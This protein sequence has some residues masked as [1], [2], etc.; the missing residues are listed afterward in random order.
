MSHVQV[1]AEDPNDAAFATPDSPYAELVWLPVLGPS[2]FLLWRHLARRLLHAPSG[3]TVDMLELSAGLGLGIGDGSQ[4]A[5]A[6]TVRRVQRFGAIRFAPPNSLH[7][8][9]ALP[10]VPRHQL[11]RLHPVVLCHHERL[12]KARRNDATSPA[13]TERSRSGRHPLPC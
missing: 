3:F 5:M 11:A 2:S 1:I 7:V 13:P 4:S 8:P 6:R 10:A 9:T 12:L